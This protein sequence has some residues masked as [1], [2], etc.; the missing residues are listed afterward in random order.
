MR[1]EVISIGDELTSGQR[2]D[3][4]SQ[5]ISERLGELGIPVMFHTTVADDLAANILVFRQACDRADIIISTGG[6]GPT[7]DDLTRQSLAE[8]AGVDLVQDEAAL[9]HI[10]ALFAR[11]KRE[12]PPSNLIQTMFPHGSQVIPNPHGSAPGIDLQIA[13]YDRGPAR[14]FALPGVPAE[15]KEMW[16]QT[17]APT[18]SER[19]SETGQRKVICHHR[20][21]CFGVGESDLEAMLPDLIRRGRVPSVGITVSKATITLRITAE[22]ESPAAALAAM[23]PTVA[24]I[25]QC[26]GDLVY[27][28][29]DDELQQAVLRMLRQREKT[30]AVAEWGTGGMISHWLSE[31]PEA[32]GT[33]WGSVIVSDGASES[34]ILGSKSRE[35]ASFGGDHEET[36]TTMASGCRERFA[37][38]YALAVGPFPAIVPAG[39]PPGTVH[40]AIASSA[41]TV[42]KSVPFT[43]HPDI[44]KVRAGKQAL[45][46]LRLNLKAAPV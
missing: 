5:W 13:R 44:L 9:A 22:G 20:I 34:R 45:D 31:C 10:Q 14:I 32:A 30:L 41:G 19:C 2:L 24:T 4:N 1:A 12:M 26:L 15:M 43:G 28:E 46:F 37:V 27:G 17:V 36:A 39:S 42:T 11:R 25:Q 29:E 8:M 40:F 7:A 23:S 3:T 6:L 35:A 16:A 21:K 38:D 18:I 33:F